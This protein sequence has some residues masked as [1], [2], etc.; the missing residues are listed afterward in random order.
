MRDAG[1]TNIVSSIS[2]MF[3]QCNYFV[4][5]LIQYVAIH[6]KHI[7]QLVIVRGP[8][9]FN[10]HCFCCVQHIDIT[11]TLLLFMLF[12]TSIHSCLSPICS[13]CPLVLS[14]WTRLYSWLN[15]AVPK[16]LH[17]PYLQSSPFL[18]VYLSITSKLS[19]FSAFHLPALLP[20][21]SCWR[22]CLC[23]CCW[24]VQHPYFPPLPPP[25]SFSTWIIIN[26]QQSK[27][28]MTFVKNFAIAVSFASYANLV[29][30]V[31]LH[32]CAPHLHSNNKS[33][34]QKNV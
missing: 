4:D 9:H 2:V 22:L 29:F 15:L 20:L 31:F 25:A 12:I 34:T 18:S 21:L 5:M 3:S 27:W 24:L 19:S 6:C 13:G 30:F 33:K 17:P 23:Q 7:M 11:R 16:L 32:A 26:Q 28:F 14:S 10:G 1:S 8:C